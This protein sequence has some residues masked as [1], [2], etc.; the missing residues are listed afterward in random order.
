MDLKS[1][2]SK[3][4]QQNNSKTSNPKDKLTTTPVNKEIMQSSR[5]IVTK[6]KNTVNEKPIRST[7]PMNVSSK[8]GAFNFKDISENKKEL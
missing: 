7:T 2:N 3:S 1:V 6:S 5:V 4:I 8:K